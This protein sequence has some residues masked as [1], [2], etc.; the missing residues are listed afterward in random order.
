MENDGTLKNSSYIGIIRITTISIA[1]IFYLIIAALLEPERYGE[2]N[3]IVALQ[4][5]FPSF[6]YLD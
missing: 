1:A 4:E 3:V 2:L 5:L 6:L